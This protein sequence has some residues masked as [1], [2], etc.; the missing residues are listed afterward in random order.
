VKAVVAEDPPRHFALNQVI[1]SA[2]FSSQPRNG[3][4]PASLGIDGP[5]RCHQP[6]HLPAKANCK[7]QRQR[8]TPRTTTKTTPTT[9]DNLDDNVGD[10]DKENDN[11]NTNDN[12]GGNADDNASNDVPLFPSPTPATMSLYSRPPQRCRIQT[13]P[14]PALLP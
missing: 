12:V 11:N 9:K 1:D 7:H 10:N 2:A 6:C 8:T 3:K 14:G 4:M 5:F 13:P